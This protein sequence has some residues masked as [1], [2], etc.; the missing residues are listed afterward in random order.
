MSSINTGSGRLVVEPLAKYLPL[1]CSGCGAQETVPEQR[2]ACG[3]CKA[4]VFC[5]LECANRNAAEHRTHCETIKETGVLFSEGALHVAADALRAT[6]RA[7]VRDVRAVLLIPEGCGEPYSVAMHGAEKLN[8]ILSDL[9]ES[10]PG[11]PA[12]LCLAEQVEVV[13]DT[14]SDVT[15]VL[16]EMFADSGTLRVAPATLVFKNVCSQCYAKTSAEHEQ[17]EVCE[18]CRAQAYCSR[19]CQRA[20]WP[21]HK[22]LCARIVPRARRDVTQLIAK[23]KS[24]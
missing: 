5:T 19:A 20:A 4:A 18:S 3:N 9:C 10:Y 14:P 21:K 17:W 2:Y 12:T 22:K 11:D 6:T 13:G 7:A 1:S 16:V 23:Q 8:S 15:F 24:K